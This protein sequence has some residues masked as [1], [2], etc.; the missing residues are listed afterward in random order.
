[1]IVTLM[2]IPRR[3]IAS[4]GVYSPR[5]TLHAMVLCIIDVENHFSEDHVRWISEK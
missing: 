5:L 1:M 2:W 4:S 3:D